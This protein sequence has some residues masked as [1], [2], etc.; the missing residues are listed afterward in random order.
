MKTFEVKSP[1]GNDE[2]L[3]L[4]LEFQGVASYWVYLCDPIVNTENWKPRKPALETNGNSEDSRL[5]SFEF[6]RPKAGEKVML[7][8]RA[9]MTSLDPKGKIEMTGKVSSV[10]TKHEIGSDSDSAQLQSGGAITLE[11]RIVLEGK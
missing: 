4:E 9:S 1:V 8:I 11:L 6:K 7:L 5:D 2:D 3:L 10:T